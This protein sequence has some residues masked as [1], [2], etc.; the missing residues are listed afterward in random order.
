MDVSVPPKMV[1]NRRSVIS[2]FNTQK[3]YLMDAFTSA[4]D[5]EKKDP[6][7]LKTDVY[8]RAWLT[9]SQD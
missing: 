9:L 4:K 5:L 8:Q 1:D 7:R 2:G 3:R 6:E